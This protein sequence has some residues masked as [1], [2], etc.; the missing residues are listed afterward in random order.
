[1]PEKSIETVLRAHSDR[2]MAL[3]GVVG[4][5][6][7]EC[8]GEPCI[9][10]LVAEATTELLRRIPSEIEGYPVDVEETGEIQAR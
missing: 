5:A 8:E 7:G 2:L 1:M 10:I 9:L 4:T 6:Q 3:P